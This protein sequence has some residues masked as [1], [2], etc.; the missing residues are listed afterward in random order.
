MDDGT[1]QLHQQAQREE[2]SK[3]AESQALASTL[4]SFMR[5]LEALHKGGVK[6]AQLKASAEQ[7]IALIPTR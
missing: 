4:L 7:M 1:R 3:E 2:R 5:G 6:A